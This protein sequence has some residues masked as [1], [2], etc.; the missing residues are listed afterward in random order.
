MLELAKHIGVTRS[1]LQRE[2]S[3]LLQSQILI[4]RRDGNRVYYQANPDCPILVDLQGLLIKTVG[5]VDVLQRA[6]AALA[7]KIEVA[8]IYGSFAQ[9][10][11]LVDSDIDLMIVG[12]VGLVQLAPILRS[13]EKTVGREVNPIVFSVSELNKK[14]A[15]GDHFLTSV[16][17]ARKIYLLGAHSDLAKTLNREQNQKTLDQQ[18]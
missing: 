2:L 12:T 9:A 6:L 3:T 17:T 8:F 18:E 16:A 1:S 5:I 13:V 14:L 10:A 4:S 11:E 15:S 7:K